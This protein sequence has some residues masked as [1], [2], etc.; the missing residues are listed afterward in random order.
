MEE[1]NMPRQPRLILDHVCYHIISRGNQK[2]TVFKEVDDYRKYMSLLLKYKNKYKLK[3][4][5]W[6]LM[7]NHVHIVIESGHLSKAMH[8]INM[9]YAQY[10]QSKYKTIGHFWQDRFK[11]FALQKDKYL[12]NCISY[13]EYNPLRAKLVTRAE[14]YKWSSYKVRALGLKNKLLDPLVI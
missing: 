1:E 4:Y 8:A 3:L 11:S 6:C 2:K 7:H 9:S 13:I 12:I 14:D 10:F 5:G